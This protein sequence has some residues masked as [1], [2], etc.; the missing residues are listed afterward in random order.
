MNDS[1]QDMDDIS[2][3][4]TITTIFELHVILTCTHWASSAGVQRELRVG[5]M[6]A[7][8]A[9]MAYVLLR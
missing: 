5:I 9:D 7:R 4:F 8:T 2:D 3:R 6:H 1:L